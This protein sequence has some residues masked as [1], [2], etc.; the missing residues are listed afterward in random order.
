MCT[1]IDGQVVM[2]LIYGIIVAEERGRVARVGKVMKC[3]SIA[4]SPQL[5][6]K[7]Q[8]IHIYITD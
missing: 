8:Y 3:G 7:A 5:H 4:T 1:G 6:G 2:R